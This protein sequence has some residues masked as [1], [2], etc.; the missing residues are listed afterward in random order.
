MK[1][2]ECWHA[3]PTQRPTFKQLVEELDRVLV[4]IS[5]EVTSFAF[6][7]IYAFGFYPVH[8]SYAFYQFAYFLRIQILIHL[9]F[10]ICSTW[11][12]PPRSNNI[13]HLV[14]T[15]PALAPQTTIQY[16]PMMLCQPTHASSG[17]MT[18]VLGWT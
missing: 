7:Y 5:D 4:S 16:L 17:T 10:C 14:K 1:M 3:V 9:Y 6:H 2:R 15:L 8:S 12:Y 18:Y 11:T 13:H